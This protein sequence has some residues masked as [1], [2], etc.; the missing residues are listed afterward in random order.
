MAS[1]KRSLSSEEDNPV[2][3]KRIL[4]DENGDPLV[5]GTTEPTEPADGDKLEVSRFSLHSE[6]ACISYSHARIFGR[7]PYIV[8]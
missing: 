5:N 8:G 6:M 7:K 2:T 4:S 3:K 1:K